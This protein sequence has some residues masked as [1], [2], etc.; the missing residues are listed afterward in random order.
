MTLPDP[1]A[2]PPKTEAF[3][4]IVD[5][6]R[7]PENAGLSDA[8]ERV[9]PTPDGSIK[10][11]DVVTIAMVAAVADADTGMWLRDQKN[12]RKIPYHLESC[13]YVPVRNESA[14][15]GLWKILGKRQAVYGRNDLWPCQRVTA[16]N[17]LAEGR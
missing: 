16:A 6:N 13:G 10:L 7:S 14:K 4:A 1:K 11:A 9:V 3:Q 12:R 5:A 2:A 8:L 17:R 15:D